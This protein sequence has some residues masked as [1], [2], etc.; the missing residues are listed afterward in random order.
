MSNIT[1]NLSALVVGCVLMLLLVT[2]C[3]SAQ[4]ATSE[5]QDNIPR[6]QYL[7]ENKCIRCHEY[8][9]PREYRQK[10]M[11]YNFNKYAA[12]SGIKKED[13]ALVL[14]WALAQSRDAP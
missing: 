7:Y 4:T 13:R 5:T 14:N 12:K 3:D 10:T 2:G 1:K 8:Y 11:R 6:A 9:D